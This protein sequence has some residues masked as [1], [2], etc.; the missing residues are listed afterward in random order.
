MNVSCA[1]ILGQGGWLTSA[2]IGVLGDRI[3]DMDVHTQVFDYTDLRDIEAFMVDARNVGDKLAI[4]SY[5]LGNSTSTWLGEHD[6]IDLLC[7]IF[8]SSLAANYPVD[9]A[10]VAHSVLFIGQDFLSDANSGG[11]D[12]VVNVTV[13]PVTIPI[14]DHLLGQDEEVVIEGVLSR[15]AKLKGAGP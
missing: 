7:C 11:F 6:K 2:G 3:A 15:I 4:V 1:V 9:K 12:E 13:T 14:L 8:E 5:S 10:N